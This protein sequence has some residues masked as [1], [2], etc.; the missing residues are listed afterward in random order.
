MRA[1]RDDPAAARHR[2]AG[3]PAALARDFGR[4]VLAERIAELALDALDAA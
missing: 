4:P 2:I 1:V 3:A